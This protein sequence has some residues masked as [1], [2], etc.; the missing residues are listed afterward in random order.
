LT[1]TQ[2]PA[3]CTRAKLF[4]KASNT[5]ELGQLAAGFVSPAGLSDAPPF[6]RTLRHCPLMGM[7]RSLRMYGTRRTDPA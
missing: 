6:R 1:I 4:A 5:C 2:D 3:P 7:D